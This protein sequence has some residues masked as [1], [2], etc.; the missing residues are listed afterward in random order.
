MRIDGLANFNDNKDIVITF[1]FPDHADRPMITS[2][3]SN[4]TTAA[5]GNATANANATAGANGNST[6]NSSQAAPVPCIDRALYRYRPGYLNETTDASTITSSF[7][8]TKQWRVW[9]LTV[10]AANVSDYFFKD[11]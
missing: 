10:P 9:T 3:V 5:N 2:D 4:T 6:N 7:D 11:E 8:D 1:T